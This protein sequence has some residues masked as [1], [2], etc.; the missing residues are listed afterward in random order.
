[1]QHDY[2]IIMRLFDYAIMHYMCATNFEP[3][4]GQGEVVLLVLIDRI[5]I[6]DQKSF[7]FQIL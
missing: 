6:M 5:Y 7:R 4:K 3:D 1:M 2:A